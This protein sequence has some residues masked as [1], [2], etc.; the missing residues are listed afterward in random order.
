MD[1]EIERVAAGCFSSRDLTKNSGYRYLGLLNIILYSLCMPP[2]TISDRLAES[3]LY[4]FS[5]SL[6]NI[7]QSQRTP[8]LPLKWNFP[9]SYEHA[10]SEPCNSAKNY[11]SLHPL[12][13][14]TSVRCHPQSVQKP[15]FTATSYQKY[16]LK[17]VFS[18][19]ETDLLPAPVG[20]FWRR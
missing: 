17:S 1:T 14:P 15:S 12:K 19:W 9:S 8:H 3:N 11:N 20:A 6:A 7:I 10:C 5:G 2:R 18:C 16:P 4:R 13:S